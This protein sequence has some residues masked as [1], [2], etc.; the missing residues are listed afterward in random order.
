MTWALLLIVGPAGRLGVAAGAVSAGLL[1]SAAAPAGG[2]E[3]S[4]AVDSAG[5]GLDFLESSPLTLLQ[6]VMVNVPD[7]RSETQS[8]TRKREFFIVET[9]NR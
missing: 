2:C 3:R 7:A 1:A 8:A 9:E 4:A 5:G 6:P